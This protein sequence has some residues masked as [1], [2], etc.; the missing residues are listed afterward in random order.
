[1][2]SPSLCEYEPVTLMLFLLYGDGVIAFIEIDG[3]DLV[4]NTLGD[5][6]VTDS[7]GVAPPHH[8]VITILYPFAYP[9]IMFALAN[10][11]AII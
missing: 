9:F 1:M 11:D 8:C 4:I 3:V 2:E 6:C 5:V 10:C 7:A